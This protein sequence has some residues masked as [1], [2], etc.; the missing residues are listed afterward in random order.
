MHVTVP[1]HSSRALF[2]CHLVTWNSMAGSCLTGSVLW[3]STGL[4]HGQ[5][6]GRSHSACQAAT[7]E[8]KCGLLEAL[9]RVPRSAKSHRRNLGKQMERAYFASR[10]VYRLAMH[11]TKK[12]QS[13]RC[14]Q[15]GCHRVWTACETCDGLSKAKAGREMRSC[16]VEA[17]GPNL[18][19]VLC[20]HLQAAGCCRSHVHKAGKKKTHWHGPNRNAEF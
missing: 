20:K 11:V 14:P 9:Q 2:K 5:V 18:A 17:H 12:L 19:T 8:S 7:S 6:S 10:L 13:G 4:R 15:N 3:L 16:A 1:V